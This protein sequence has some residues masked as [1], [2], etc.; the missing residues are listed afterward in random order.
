MVQVLKDVVKRGTPESNIDFQDTNQ[1]IIDFSSMHM[2][3]VY[4]V[5]NVV[6]TEIKLRERHLATQVKAAHQDLRR[7]KSEIQEV[8]QKKWEEDG[9]YQRISEAVTFSCSILEKEGITPKMHPDAKIA[10]L[11]ELVIDLKKKVVQLE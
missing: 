7:L 3:E 4:A 1:L 6:N 11:A 8:E 10:Q 9:N 5:Q 2:N